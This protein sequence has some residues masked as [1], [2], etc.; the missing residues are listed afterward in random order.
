MLLYI[1]SMFAFKFAARIV[2]DKTAL[3]A[4]L[5][6]VPSIVVDGLLSRFTETSRDKNEYVP[7]QLNI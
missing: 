5:Q 7:I 1:S 4:R 3:Q 2:N 6:D